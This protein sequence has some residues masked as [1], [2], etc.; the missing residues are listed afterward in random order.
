MDEKIKE[1]LAIQIANKAIQIAVLQ[2]E[3]SRLNNIIDQ[4]TADLDQATAPA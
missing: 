3:N 4:L 1:N 2:A